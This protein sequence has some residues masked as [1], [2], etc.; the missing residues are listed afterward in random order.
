MKIQLDDIYPDH[1]IEV[2]PSLYGLVITASVDEEEYAVLNLTRG[3]TVELI[4]SILRCF[5][6]KDYH[7]E[8]ISLREVEEE[9]VR[10]T[11][12]NL[13]PGYHVGK[14]GAI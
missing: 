9:L 10:Q 3:Q 7:K 5:H 6:D 4:A 11:F 12:N 13:P 2:E 14:L 1:Y 8:G